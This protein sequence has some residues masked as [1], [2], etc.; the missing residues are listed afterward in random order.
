VPGDYPT[1]QTAIDS[2]FPGDTIIVAPGTYMEN[3]DFKGKSITVM[4]SDGPLSTVIDGGN[5]S[6]PDIGTVVT[7]VSGEGP[8]AIL[9]GF[10]ITNGSGTKVSV[11]KYPEVETAGGGIRVKDN[12]SPTLRQN[13]VTKNRADVG[14]GISVSWVSTGCTSITYNCISENEALYWGGGLSCG[15]ADA[16]IRFNTFIGNSAEFP[17]Y[18]S[19]GG[20][21]LASEGHFNI[22]GNSILSNRTIENGG[23]ISIWKGSAEIE[24]NLFSY[25]YCCYS[26]GGLFFRECY[27]IRIVGNTII[28]NQV[29]YSGGGICFFDYCHPL[30]VTGNIITRNAASQGGGIQFRVMGSV[31]FSNN[32]LYENSAYNGGAVSCMA[33][34]V[35]RISNSVL[36]NNTATC[37]SEIWIGSNLLDPST[38]AISHCNVQGGQ[39]SVYLGTNGS[40]DWGSGMI[41][42]DP[43]FVNAGIGDFHLCHP[44]PCRDAGD[45]ATAMVTDFDFEGDPRIAS[46]TVDMGADEFHPHLY[47][48]GKF[49]PGGP[50]QC[51]VIGDPGT[52]PL[53]LFYGLEVLEPPMPT[54]WGDFYLSPLLTPMVLGQVPV[55]TGVGIVH[56]N[57]PTAPAG[58]YE[59]PMQALIGNALSNLYVIEVK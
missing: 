52:S 47:F 15:I 51:K 58:P 56:V 44:S 8:E 59:I 7:F 25:N 45:N 48:T 42:E 36:W 33:S 19:W 22:I 43:C 38:L 17:N 14:A 10:T 3:I 34:Q 23:G 31:S 24:G 18:G 1:I 49:T 16:D 40:I 13:I 39:A 35:D 32:T 30:T 20:G 5:P 4:S 26:G 9:Q 6:N 2:A 41:D 21:I 37:G 28:G 29:V 12:S 57:L 50:I 27:D 54:Q 55:P 11:P 46:G 53:W